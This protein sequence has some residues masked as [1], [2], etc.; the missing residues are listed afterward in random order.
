MSFERFG[1][2]GRGSLYTVLGSH[3]AV[4]TESCFQIRPAMEMKPM[5]TYNNGKY[6]TEL[7]QNSTHPPTYFRSSLG[8]SYYLRQEECHLSHPYSMLYRGNKGKKKNICYS[9]SRESH[10]R[11]STVHS[12]TGAHP[13]AWGWLYCV[14]AYFCTLI[15]DY[16]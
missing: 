16:R 7:M 13:R 15:C 4:S 2:L 10:R 9:S 6:F 12:Y 3:P 11:A 8:G 1:A 5:E 14:A